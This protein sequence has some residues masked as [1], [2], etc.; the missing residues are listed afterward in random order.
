M[1]H[2]T[3][4]QFWWQQ[5]KSQGIAGIHLLGTM[6]RLRQMSCLIH[7]IVFSVDQP[8]D[9]AIPIATLTKISWLNCMNAKHIST[10]ERVWEQ[11]LFHVLLMPFFWQQNK[12][13]NICR[14]VSSVFGISI[15][16]NTHNL[17][18][19][20]Q[21]VTSTPFS[22]WL[23]NTVVTGS[24]VPA[25]LVLPP[26][27]EVPL[28][29]SWPRTFECGVCMF[30][31]CLCQFPTTPKDAACFMLLCGIVKQSLSEMILSMGLNHILNVTQIGHM[32]WSER[33]TDMQHK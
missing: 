14:L 11:H 17:F 32:V 2:L 15:S 33:F 23:L 8:P 7:P 25:W 16:N 28:F 4:K 10:A 12:V 18:Q 30:L 31:L 13:T 24:M 3:L 26:H 9:I 6:K 1:F 22:L 20:P 29:Q 19:F 5:S 27:S 21:N